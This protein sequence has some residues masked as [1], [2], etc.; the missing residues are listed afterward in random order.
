M[1]ISGPGIQSDF[2]LASTICG[3]SWTDQPRTLL[4]PPKCSCCGRAWPLSNTQQQCH[5]LGKCKKKSEPHKVLNEGISLRPG[6]PDAFWCK[7]LIFLRSI[8]KPAPSKAPA[9]FSTESGIQ[10]R[11]GDRGTTRTHHSFHDPLN[12]LPNLTSGSGMLRVHSRDFC[13]APNQEIPSRDNRHS[14]HTVSSCYLTPAV[15]RWQ[16]KC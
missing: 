6:R 2:S 16:E 14:L 8:P 15:K 11:V 9:F 12:L 13:I 5:A 4:L 3:V 10:L 7:A 1:P